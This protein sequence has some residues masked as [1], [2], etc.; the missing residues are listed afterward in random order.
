MSWKDFEN[1]LSMA[2]AHE[3]ARASLKTRQCHVTVTY[4]AANSKVYSFKTCMGSC[5]KC[6]AI[7][8]LVRMALT[9]VKVVDVRAP[10]ATSPA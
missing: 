1:A 6:D 3:L 2:R 7:W 9:S 8:V 4:P 10:E 5:S